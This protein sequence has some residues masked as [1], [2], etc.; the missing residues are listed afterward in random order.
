MILIVKIQIGLLGFPRLNRLGSRSIELLLSDKLVVPALPSSLCHFSVAAIACLCS[1]C[2]SLRGVA[3][4]DTDD[5]SFSPAPAS[6]LLL[7]LLPSVH[8]FSALDTVVPVVPSFCFWVRR[9]VPLISS[10]SSVLSRYLT[11]PL[12]SPPLPDRYYSS[13]H[14]RFCC[15]ISCPC[16][17]YVHTRRS[18][19]KMVLLLTLGRKTELVSSSCTYQQL[20]ETRACEA[21]PVP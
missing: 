10:C 16:V 13:L 17:S 5:C 6:L 18:K 4:G 20:E 12:P 7:L 1:L 21:S 11:S 3:L 15:I 9:R 2:L 14:S 19:N 8:T